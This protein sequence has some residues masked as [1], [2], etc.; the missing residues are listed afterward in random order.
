VK[1]DERATPLALVVYVSDT[2]PFANVPLAP[3]VGA[4][5][6]TDTPL[7]GDPPVVTVTISGAANGVPTVAICGDPLVIMIATTG[8]FELNP[9]RP[10]QLGKNAIRQTKAKIVP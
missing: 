8:V 4:V 7:V 1:V 6:V 2:V 5:K 10:P 3:V 9:L